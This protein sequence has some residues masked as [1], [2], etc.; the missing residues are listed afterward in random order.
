M[1][2]LA[3][4]PGPPP[5]SRDHYRRC[6]TSVRI[7]DGR[8][9]SG[10]TPDNHGFAPLKLRRSKKGAAVPNK[11]AAGSGPGPTGEISGHQASATGAGA[12]ARS[13]S[14]RP[15]VGWPCWWR[16]WPRSSRPRCCRA[17]GRACADLWAQQVARS[18][19]SVGGRRIL[20]DERASRYN[21]GR[22]M[23]TEDRIKPLEV[24]PP[25]TADGVLPPVNASRP[26]DVE[27]SPYPVSLTAYVRRFGSTPERQ[28]ILGGLL[29]YR[30]ALH[31]AGLNAGFQWLDGSFVENIE[32]IEQRAPNDV[33]VVTFYRRPAGVSQKQ[34]ADKVGSLFRNR[35]TKA[36]YHVDGYV[37]DLETKPESLT[38]WSAYWYSMWSHRRNIIWKGF[39]QV[40]LA[41]AED[42]TAATALVA[43]ATN[44]R[45]P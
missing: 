43:L 8:P 26:T 45:R 20:E 37:V 31:E 35:F 1:P 29:R 6:P 40:D 24:V 23:A 32:L 13:S 36:T 19:L 30:A 15:R 39:V 5:T 17:H 11:G 14:A 33:D 18:D 4:S 25:W 16:S 9:R 22:I 2:G 44:G 27:R 12:C 38:K 34:L 7:P 28:A 10:Q 3:A 21:R 42:A 41:P